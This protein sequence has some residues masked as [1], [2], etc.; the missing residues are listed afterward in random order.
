MWRDTDML[1][2][3][4]F[5]KLDDDELEKVSGGEQEQNELNADDYVT[6]YCNECKCITRWKYNGKG[7]YHCEG[8]CDILTSII[9]SL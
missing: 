6:G 1:D 2:E 8:G 4:R 9:P 5:R 7:M 3:K